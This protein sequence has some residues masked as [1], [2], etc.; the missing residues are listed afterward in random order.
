MD[1]LNT[2]AERL[3]DEIATLPAGYISQKNIRGKVQYYLQWKEDGKLKSKYVRESD[4]PELEK[5]IERRKR[6]QAKRK[7]L[8]KML[9]KN[10]GALSLETNVV[11]G[12]HLLAM[13]DH[14]RALEKRDLYGNLKDYLDGREWDRVCVVYGLR[15]TGKTTMLLQAVA[16]MTEEQAAKAFYLK[17]RR[18]DTMAA[19]NRDL[20]KLY[21]NGYRYALIDEITL[22]KDFVD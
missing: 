19:I 8:L 9:P 16:D 20:G 10:N 1:D 21:E 3:G 7:E 18:S 13:A 11:T 15:R 14:V 22:V 6:L 5:Q 4:L 17:A 12:E 2:L